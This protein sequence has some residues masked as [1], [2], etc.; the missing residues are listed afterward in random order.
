MKF[1]VEITGQIEQRLA[2][3]AKRLNISADQLAAA[4]VRNLVPSTDEEVSRSQRAF[5]KTASSIGA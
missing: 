3:A 2:E 4:A 5:W 1:S